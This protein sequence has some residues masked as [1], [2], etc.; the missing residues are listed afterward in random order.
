MLDGINLPRA[1]FAKRLFAKTGRAGI[2]NVASLFVGLFGVLQYAY[3][4]G[5]SCNMRRDCGGGVSHYA[6]RF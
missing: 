4:L 6:R 3:S 5:K 1:S 2:G